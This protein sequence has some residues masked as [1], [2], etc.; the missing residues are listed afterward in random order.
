M[1]I[2]KNTPFKFDKLFCIASDCDMM[3]INFLNN[4]INNINI[5]YGLSITNSFWIRGGEDSISMFNNNNDIQN[6]SLIVRHYHNGYLDHLH[7]WHSDNK[8]ISVFDRESF[9]INN[10]KIILKI[11]NKKSTNY[12][13]FR[14]DFKCNS[15]WYN[16]KDKLENDDNIKLNILNNGDYIINIDKFTNFLNTYINTTVINLYLGLNSIISNVVL[17]YGNDNII[18]YTNDEIEKNIYICGNYKILSLITEKLHY[19]TNKINYINFE[20]D[21]LDLK[22]I[23]LGIINKEIQE[24]QEKILDNYC[25]K[26]IYMSEHGGWTHNNRIFQTEM[27][28]RNDQHIIYDY[29]PVK[30]ITGIPNTLNDN[31][32]NMYYNFDKK[33]IEVNTYELKKDLQELIQKFN[34]QNIVSGGGNIPLLIDKSLN[35]SGDDFWYTHIGTLNADINRDFYPDEYLKYFKDLSFNYYGINKY[36]NRLFICSPSFY[37]KYKTI[38]QEIKNN[39]R[40][41]DNDIYI[42]SWLSS[43]RNYLWLNK[44]AWSS[45][46]SY[47]T[48]YTPCESSKLFINNIE[49]NNYIRNIKDNTDKY[50]ITIVDITTPVI[51]LSDLPI[52]HNGYN[53]VNL[54]NQTTFKNDKIISIYENN[55]DISYIKLIIDNQISYNTS[56]LYINFETY[57]KKDTDFNIILDVDGKKI[58]IV[59]NSNIDNNIDSYW[60]INNINDKMEYYLP[61]YDL[62][63]INKELAFPN[64]K[65]KEVTV[66]IKEGTIGDYI[67]I[68][69][70]SLLRSNPCYDN[71]DKYL[72]SGI[73]TEDN[74]P[75]KDALLE[76]I[77]KNDEVFIS[78]T[79]STG[80]Y[81]FKLEKNIIYKI[82]CSYK[83]KL[84]ETKWRKNLKNEVNLNICL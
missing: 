83:N 20:S 35:S 28:I 12:T 15:V 82:K 39:I 54:S 65:I 79:D 6:K 51:L 13:F 24:D 33:F 70:L 43:K 59:N 64:G 31:C 76:L 52:Y 78:N 41:I 55:V 49:Q 21:E 84:Y 81:D 8:R 11:L 68:K 40:I 38:Q 29:N 57:F 5:K 4:F 67:H 47:I 77:T 66:M 19:K 61:V 69:E 80:F 22:L 62:V 50:S 27:L 9:S 1:D 2:I 45:D 36:N 16:N 25:I 58:A 37:V 53:N 26:P 7:G 17:N 44:D 71:E 30:Y 18:H 48:I 75:I 23:T 42:N 72:I 73:V 10:N 3:T 60:T 46:L 74:I 56:H 34:I 63:F 14:K 32:K